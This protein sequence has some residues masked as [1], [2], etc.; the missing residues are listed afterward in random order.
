MGIAQ[1]KALFSPQRFP[2]LTWAQR[3]QLLR[4]RYHRYAPCYRNFSGHRLSARAIAQQRRVNDAVLAQGAVHWGESPRNAAWFM[5]WLRSAQQRVPYFAGVDSLNTVSWQALPT[6]SREHLATRLNQHVPVDVL[7]QP[8]LLCFSTSGTTGHPI[9]VPS[10]PSVAAQYAAYHQRALAAHG[11]VLTAGAGDVGVALVGF[12]ARCFS[13]VS[14]NPFNGSG[15]VKLNLNPLDWQRDSDRAAYLNALRPE[16]ITGDPLS[17]A[18]LSALAVTHQ[19]K[20]ILSTSMALASGLRESLSL[21][22]AC[23]VIDVYSMNEAGP[24]AAWVTQ[25]GGHL[26]LQPELFVEILDD[27]GHAVAAGQRGEITLTGGFNPCLPLLRY[28]TGDYASKISTPSGDV[29]VGLSGR[30]PVRFQT[31][32]GA[33]VNNVD[34]TQALHPFG[35]TRFSLHQAASGALTLSTEPVVQD[36]AAQHTLRAVLSERFLN[37]LPPLS[38]APVQADDKIHQYRSELPAA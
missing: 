35:F 7:T 34:I 3:W 19:P 5:P 13:Y 28:R 4:L 29:L 18:A 1:L 25:L 10:L 31:R 37:A 9:H 30:A 11:L 20:A 22:F 15:L 26:L 33:W 14:V 32:A 27:A 12:Q 38:F 8:A 23:C 36:T 21:R 6:M 16:L 17:L 2:Q 24:I